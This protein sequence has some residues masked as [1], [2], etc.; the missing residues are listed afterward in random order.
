MHAW[1][2]SVIAGHR[3]AA[4]VI[5]AG[6]GLLA[7]LASGR[8]WAACIGLLA[9]GLYYALATRRYR[10]RLG[11]AL[12]P[13]HAALLER[14]VP[15]YRRLGDDG[16]RRFETDVCIFM[17][18]QTVTGIAGK[19]VDDE[20]RVLIAASAAMLTHGMPDF[21][22]P[23]VRDIVVYPRSF[24]EKYDARG[25]HIAGMVHL[26]GPILFSRRDLRH[27]FQARD[28]HHVGI[29]EM[30]HVIDMLDGSA[31]GVPGDLPWVS[32][33]P[34]IKVVAQRLRRVRGR[35]HVLRDY[36]GT[37]EAEL[38]AV[39]VEAFFEQPDKLA[40]RDREL[41]DML[42]DYFNQDP[43]QTGD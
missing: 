20:A 7:A 18:E 2:R 29:H 12:A 24:D 33:A 19:A 11:L 15:F 14:A 5:G 40:R 23:R 16:K 10:R 42:R 1:P 37:N 9:G 31:D 21:E 38:F 4:V 32:S 39:A 41:F 30:A 8:W 27:G 34:W 22:W 13:E 3:I 25:G 43:R 36:A 17:T 26:H 28:G 35:H 6:A